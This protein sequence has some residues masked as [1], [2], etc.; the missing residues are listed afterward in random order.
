MSV[1]LESSPPAMGRV[2][3]SVDGAM[4]GLG[5]KAAFSAVS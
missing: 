5:Q 4:S 1:K 3:A 2:K